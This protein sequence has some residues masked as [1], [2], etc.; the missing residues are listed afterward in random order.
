MW[1]NRRR[2]WTSSVQFYRS[3]SQRLW[4]VERQIDAQDDLQLLKNDSSLLLSLTAILP[5]IEPRIEVNAGPPKPSLG[6]AADGVA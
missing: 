3:Q 2:H 4:C 6:A 5:S 1:T